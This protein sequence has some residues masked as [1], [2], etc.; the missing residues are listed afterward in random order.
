V[1][2]LLV[3]TTGVIPYRELLVRKLKKI[4][5]KLNVRLPHSLLRTN[6]VTASQSALDSLSLSV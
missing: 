3:V 2:Q 5:S 1:R 4:L 6:T